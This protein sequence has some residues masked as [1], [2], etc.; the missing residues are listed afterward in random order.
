M[1]GN[2]S[3]SQLD[4]AQSL[5]GIYM[6]AYA[7]TA[8]Y[9]VPASLFF[10][11]TGGTIVTSGSTVT[12]D[13]DD[14]LIILNKS[15]AGPTT[16]ML[17]AVANRSG[18][19]VTIVDWA[20]NAGDITVNAFAGDTIQGSASMTVGSSGQGVGTS[21]NFTLTPIPSLSGWTAK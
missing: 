6:A 10:P 2:K 7:G 19:P 3:I 8:N 4:T 15:I 9:K 14:A 12:V 20:G 5:L 13:D 21:A 16:I 18:I 11:G 17:G 1:S